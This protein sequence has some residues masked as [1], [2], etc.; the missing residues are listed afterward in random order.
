[1]F[2]PERF[3][4]A[5]MIWVCTVAIGMLLRALVHQGVAL[6]FV[7]VASIATA[8]FLF[9]WRAIA[10]AVVRRRAGAGRQTSAI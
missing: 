4:P 1:M 9:G 10:A 6:S 5:I 3:R 2:R 8:V 7:I